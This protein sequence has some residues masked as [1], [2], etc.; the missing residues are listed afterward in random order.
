M[1]GQ[2]LPF[3]LFSLGL[4]SFSA[5]ADSDATNGGVSLDIQEWEVP[6]EGPR[7]RDPWVGGDDTIW[8]VRQVTH[9]VGRLTPSTGEFKQYFLG[10]GAGPHTVISDNRGVWYAGNRDAHIG[11]LDPETGDIQRFVPPG[12]GRRDVHTMDFD[13]QGRI[14]F[15]E[16]GGN[17]IGRFDPDTEEFQMYD[18]PTQGARPYGIV[19]HNDQPWAVLFGTHKLATIDNG[20]LVEIDLPREEARPRRLAVSSQGH[21][22]YGDYA[23][24]YVG[25]YEPETG[26]IEE[27][28]APS[29]EQSKPYAVA[30]DGEDRFWIV[31]TGVSP[32]VFVAFDTQT[33]TWSQSFAIPSRGEVVR[34]MVYE[35]KENAIWFGTDS[36]TIGIARIQ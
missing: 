18:V 36:N 35:P 23:G 20:E 2:W 8:F 31:E 3:I 32:N 13:S 27:W 33:H 10:E 25:R 22:Y 17:R 12:E 34:H 19:V 6:Y 9:Y 28:R 16:Q 7:S 5:A 1:K 24:G 4:M 14:W 21:V 29:A 30:M 15:T 26:E 11:L